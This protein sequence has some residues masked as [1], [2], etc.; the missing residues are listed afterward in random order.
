MKLTFT[1][2]LPEG[3]AVTLTAEWDGDASH[4]ANSGTFE[5]DARGPTNKDAVA[6]FTDV[7]ARF[8]VAI[9]EAFEIVLD[10][11]EPPLLF[12]PQS[13]LVH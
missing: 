7:F 11:R 1:T 5:P 8:Q 12:D 13:P 9:K 3:F 10:W 2:P 6:A 4:T